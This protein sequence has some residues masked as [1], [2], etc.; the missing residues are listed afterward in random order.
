MRSDPRSLMTG[1]PLN[2]SLCPF[3]S[4][5]QCHSCFYLLSAGSLLETQKPWKGMASTRKGTS[6]L[7]PKP[8]RGDLRS[9]ASWE[10]FSI[11]SKV[12]GKE[13]HNLSQLYM[14]VW[15]A[16]QDIK[17][18]LQSI[19][20]LISRAIGSES[21]IKCKIP[22]SCYIVS[23]FF[24]HSNI[25]F[26]LLFFFFFLTATPTAYGGSQA[27][28]WVGTVAA[29]YVIAIA[30]HDASHICDYTRAH[31]NI[32]SLTHWARPGIE[33]ISSWTLCQVLNPLRQDGN[34]IFFSW[35]SCLHDLSSVFFFISLSLESEIKTQLKQPHWSTET[36]D[37][38]AHGRERKQ[39]FDLL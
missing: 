25:L 27:Q 7:G 1:P 3:H 13:M 36:Y 33:P 28:G 10:V 16:Y 11:S 14:W 15:S 18:L 19:W 22:G 20:K 2:S 5:W 12:R 30:I 24:V 26:F 31:S 23:Q 37:F 29:A 17:G 34:S 32:G 38:K 39:I 35:L 8:P 6:K 21:F 9:D 4:A